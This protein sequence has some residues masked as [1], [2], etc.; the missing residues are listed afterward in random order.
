[1]EVASITPPAA[2]N[3]A[4]PLT[5]TSPLFHIQI[6]THTLAHGSADIFTHSPHEQRLSCNVLACPVLSFRILSCLPSSAFPPSA[7]TTLLFLPLK[8]QQ[9]RGPPCPAWL[10]PVSGS[11]AG[12][13]CPGCS[14]W[15]MP[16]LSRCRGCGPQY[17]I[18]GYLHV[19]D[20]KRVQ[21]GPN[22]VGVRGTVISAAVYLRGFSFLYIRLW[23]SECGFKTHGRSF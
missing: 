22:G 13:T 19:R 20:N 11:F 16:A 3:N 1:M 23:V 7:L 8:P 14:I 15:Q 2:D 10:A 9:L 21:K 6:H 18:F 4:G 5:H 17:K 12:F